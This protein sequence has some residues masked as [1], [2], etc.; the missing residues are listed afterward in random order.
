MAV[1]RKSHS[2]VHLL[3]HAHSEANSKGILAGR[4]PGVH[5]SQIG[6]EE[7]KLL[8]E[9]LKALK[10]DFLHVSP[11]E[12]CWET[13]QPFVD[14]TS[15]IEISQDSKF[16]EMDYGLWSGQKLKNLTKKN[17]WSSIQNSPSVVRF[18]EGESFNEMHGRAIEGVEEIRKNPG[19]HLVVSHGDV[20]RV[21]LNN[22]LGSHMDLFQR[23]SIA[24]ASISSIVFQG[25]SISITSVN[26][27]LQRKPD[28]SL[29]ESTLGGGSGR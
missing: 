17:L 23:L 20:I 19:V 28:E 9:P 11:L 7:A 21:I 27:I 3:R 8:V 15:G 24:P 6:K 4:K 18:P 2:V 13:I 10:V 5:L 1:N 29:G 25:N 14:A 16:I 12:R 26:R 22:Y